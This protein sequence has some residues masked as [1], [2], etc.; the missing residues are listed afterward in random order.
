M[1]MDKFCDERFF[2]PECTYFTHF[3]GDFHGFESG[4]ATLVSFVASMG[5]GGGTEKT[6]AGRPN[7]YYAST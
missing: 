4:K 3:L 7:A 1:R 6:A 5:K 2:L